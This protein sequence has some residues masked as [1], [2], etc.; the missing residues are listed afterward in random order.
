VIVCRECGSQNDD[1][2]RFCQSCRAYLRWKDSAPSPV[3]EP[4]APEDVPGELVA[5][6]PRVSTPPVEVVA[7]EVIE[8]AQTVTPPESVEMP[9]EHEETTPDP[10]ESTLEHAQPTPEPGSSPDELEAEAAE[11]QRPQGEPIRTSRQAAA[12]IAAE[13]GAAKGFGAEPPSDVEA[14]ADAVVAV[15]PKT[16]APFGSEE[17]GQEAAKE[18]PVIDLT[19]REAQPGD[20]IC[21]KCSE[22]NE[23]TRTYC[24][25]CGQDLAEAPIVPPPHLPW[26]RRI[27]RKRRREPKLRRPPRR[28]N[29]GKIA[30]GIAVLLAAALAIPGVRNAA[31]DLFGEARKRALPRF[32]AVNPT[33]AKA[34]SV[35]TGHPATAAVDGVRNTYWAEGAKG[36]GEKQVLTVAFGQSVSIARIIITPGASAKVE[37]FRAQPRPKVLHLI[38]SNGKTADISL[39]DKPEA[40]DFPVDVEGANSVEIHIVSVYGS[41]KGSAASI[42][43]IEF[44]ARA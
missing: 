16:A 13:S 39:E 27:F 32:V 40:Q 7:T 44:R 31:T 19:K 21:Q 25:S 35:L 43:E 38:F 24:H 14:E 18:A 1:G 3:A 30:A 10:E 42:A 12:L 36:S 6:P 37:E 28:L 17:P 22:P 34:T 9:T 4:P 15:E 23:P 29:T 41:I 33:G 5:A 20:L 11:A 8:E 26:W 2:A